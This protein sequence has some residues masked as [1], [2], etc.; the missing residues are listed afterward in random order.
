MNSQI[1]VNCSNKKDVNTTNNRLVTESCGHVKCMECLLQEKSGC[2]ACQNEIND[3]ISNGSD[4]DVSKTLAVEYGVN[5]V[6]IDNNRSP[7]IAKTEKK[8]P[9]TSHI[10]VEIVGKTKTY[11]CLVCN[12][13]FHARSMVAYHAYCNGQT[14][15]YQCPFPECNKSFTSMSYYQYH[16][17]VHSGDRAFPCNVCGKSFFQKSKMMR[18]SMKHS[19][20][21]KYICEVC[22]KG[23][24]NSTALRRHALTHTE[25]RPYCCTICGQRFRDSSNFRKHVIKHENMGKSPAPDSTV[26]RE[27]RAHKCVYTRC[28]QA[29]YSRKDL[30]RHMQVH[31]DTKPYRCKACE[32]ERRFRRKDNLDRHIRHSHPG[33]APAMAAVREE[34]PVTAACFEN[35]HAESEDDPKKFTDEVSEKKKLEFLNPLPPLPLEVIEQHMATETVDDITSDD[36]VID[37]PVVDNNTEKRVIDTSY[38]LQANNARDSVI[39]GT[40]T[41]RKTTSPVPEYVHKIRRANSLICNKET[42]LPP[43]DPTK[44]IELETKTTLNHLDIGVPSPKNIET[45]KNILYDK[46]ENNGGEEEKAPEIHWRRKMKLGIN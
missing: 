2:I 3:D 27:L 18:H 7:E 37:A 6:N 26:R 44:I 22:T 25:E 32:V 4:F 42:G 28:K 35:G 17:R 14:K 46:L 15:P 31:T 33:L 16:M 36:T 13:K 29:F 19:K 24:S 20:D 43:I 30:R 41:D 38:I 40:C 1:C 23:F 11:K 8:K 5:D 21:K 12:K 9:E 10:Q 34:A 45:Y 39:V